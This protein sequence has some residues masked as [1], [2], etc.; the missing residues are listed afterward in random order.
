MVKAPQK[1]CSGTTRH[2]AA[3]KIGV[4]FPHL[5]GRVENHTRLVQ[6][7]K[8][9]NQTS[10]VI[11]TLSIDYFSSIVDVCLPP[12]WLPSMFVYPR[13]NCL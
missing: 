4:H 10:L 12:R 13:G 9:V 11:K 2:V 5:H 3:V 8:S 7:R 6:R 1:T